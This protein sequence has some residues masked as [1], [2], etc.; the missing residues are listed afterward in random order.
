MLLRVKWRSPFPRKT[1]IMRYSASPTL[2]VDK[3]RAN[4]RCASSTRA[5]LT[6]S[7]TCA[8]KLCVVGALARDVQKLATRE[9]AT[10]VVDPCRCLWG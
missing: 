8:D 3:A 9:A 6:Q 10:V 1:A 5:A 7:L 2:K 4:P